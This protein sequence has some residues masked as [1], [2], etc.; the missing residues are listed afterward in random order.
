MTNEKAPQQ[1]KDRIRAARRAAEGDP[2]LVGFDA[3]GI[4]ELITASSRPVAM[5]GASAMVS[6]FDTWARDRPGS[7]FG[8]GGRGVWLVEGSSAAD[9][10]RDTLVREYA[11]RT[12]GGVLACATAR[13]DPARESDSLALLRLRLKNAK[14]EAPPPRV[15]LPRSRAEQCAYCRVRAASTTRRPPGA[16][17]H[18][19]CARCDDSVERGGTRARTRHE[20]GQTLED[21]ALG[22]RVA[23]IAADGNSM[24]VFFA[25]VG[26][27]MEMAAASQVVDAVFRGAH[28]AALSEIPEAPRISLVTGGDDILLFLAPDFLLDY[29]TLLAQK[30]HEQT[31]A[32]SGL[33][34]LLGDKLRSSLQRVGIGVG[35]VVAPFHYPASRLLEYAHDYEKSAKSICRGGDGARSAFDLAV[36][37]SGNELTQGRQHCWAEEIPGAK[38]SDLRRRASALADI[39][40]SQLAR[41]IGTGD[42]DDV[43]RRNLFRY[44][45]AR[46]A[47]WQKWFQQIGRDWRSRSQVD[48]ALPDE[49]LVCLAGLERQRQRC[50]GSRAHG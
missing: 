44:Q 34:T 9:M 41:L 39:P 15:P 24:G 38:W 35:A 30:V 2:F 28:E 4:Q 23:A 7:I 14:D 32:S 26:S 49:R 46:S 17:A 42:L 29:V 22:G 48:E 10:A 16:E 37:T 25:E 13:L 31:R 6:A 18:S 1:L 47:P 20:Q 3:N 11:D 40:A 8:G 50:A 5:C 27:L 45:V 19:I 36:L 21:L 33:V 12:H 43:E